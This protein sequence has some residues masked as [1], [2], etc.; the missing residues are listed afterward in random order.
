ME[1][2]IIPL[3]NIPLTPSNSIIIA[4]KVQVKLLKL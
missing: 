3:Y 2:K 4:E 1:V